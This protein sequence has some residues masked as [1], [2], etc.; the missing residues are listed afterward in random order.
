M[1]KKKDTEMNNIVIKTTKAEQVGEAFLSRRRG[2]LFCTYNLK[3]TVYWYGKILIGGNVIGHGAGRFVLP[4][5]SY[6]N[7]DPE[8]WQMES[9]F[10]RT[11]GF[12][13]CLNPTMKTRSLTKYEEHLLSIAEADIGP[14]VREKAAE[15]VA[16]LQEALAK[17]EKG[18]KV[19]L[20][21]EPTENTDKEEE[22]SAARQKKA[23]E[24]GRELHL[25]M[26]GPKYHA[27]I[28]G[29]ELYD[30]GIV[31]LSCCS[32]DDEDLAAVLDVLKTERGK[33]VTSL[34]LSFNSIEDYGLQL[35]CAALGG[36]AAPN[37]QE[38]KLGHNHKMSEK[39]SKAIV[40]GLSM[41]R[42]GVKVSI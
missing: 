13:A 27:F 17:A 10:D 28:K 15:I 16:T 30:K 41:L 29:E 5:V 22:L 12:G 37:L 11:G 7:P 26:V 21:A 2:K 8:K 19:L 32:I 33:T 20:G 31:S 34:D 40:K 35:I 23:D 3:I 25:Q 9:D 36:G 24:Y 14:I 6:D 1:G 38:L 39:V 42:K 18:E 4:E